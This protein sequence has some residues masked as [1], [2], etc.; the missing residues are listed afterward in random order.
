MKLLL[1]ITLILVLGLSLQDISV[2]QPQSLYAKIKDSQGRA[3]YL[4]YSV[5]TFGYLDYQASFRMRVLP[6]GGDKHGCKFED[7]DIP[8]KI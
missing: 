7:Y 2:Q 5:S 8:G 1:L 3:G 6:I 4:D